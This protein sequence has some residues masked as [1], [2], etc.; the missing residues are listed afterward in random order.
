LQQKTGI[1]FFI[2]RT[3]ADKDI[4]IQISQILQAAGYKTLLQDEDFGHT[5]FMAMMEDGFLEVDKN[6]RL[7]ALLSKQYPQSAHCRAEYNYPLTHDP[8]NRDEKLIVLRIEECAPT[9][10]LKPLPYVDLVPTVHDIQRLQTAV[11]LAVGHLDAHIKTEP[12]W[13]A[14]LKRA[15]QQIRHS[16][17]RATPNFTGRQDE[18]SALHDAL[19]KTEDGIAA[20]TQPT[21]VHGLGGVGKSILAKEYAWQNKES[22]QGVWWLDA[23]EE[24]EIT[25]GLIELGAH[26]IPGLK[27]MTEK[28][29]AATATLDY[30]ATHFEGDKKPWL[31][32]YDNIE[33]EEIYR[34]HAPKGGAQVLLTSRQSHFTN[35]ITPIEINSWPLGD[36]I[37]YLRDESGRSFDEAQA[38]TLAET[39][40]CMPLALSHAAAF[41]RQNHAITV[42]TYLRNIETYLNK[43]PEKA[44]Y[45]DAVF[46]TY[47]TAIVGC[48]TRAPGAKAL[49]SLAAFMAPDNIPYEIYSQEAEDY[50]AA[51]QPLI[52]NE[53][54]FLDALG[55][56][57]RF[58]LISLEADNKTFSLHRLVQAAAKDSLNEE[59]ETWLAS[60]IN[61]LVEAYPG[62]DFNDWPAFERLLPHGQHIDASAPDDIEAPLGTLLNDIAVYLKDRADYQTAEP[63]FRRALESDEK[64]FGP[65]HPNVAI[66]LNNLALLLKDTNRPEEAE[67]L[68]R[69][70][71]ESHEKNFGPDHP[72]VA[73]HLNN[74][75]LLLK[76]TNRPEEAEPLYRRA[77]VSDE[78]NF[79]P[80]H[81][82]VAR[83]LN[84]LAG[85]LKDTNRPEEAEPLYRRALESDEKNFGPDHPNVAIDLNNL[86]ALLRTTNR[87]EEAE[88]LYRRALESDEKNFGPDHPNVAIRLNNLALLLKDTNRPKEAEPL[89][90][91]ALESNEKNF[92][93]DHPNVARDLNNLAGLLKGTNRPEEAEPLFH[94]SLAILEAS[95]PEGHPSIETVRQNLAILLQDLNEE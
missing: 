48:E 89:Y 47:Q 28:Q 42:E 52:E 2:S 35:Q 51:L 38:T 54:L 7:I 60:G 40:G 27:E 85:L 25:T 90:R 13:F 58:S 15:S 61:A 29:T 50:P 36:A 68:F 6:A 91:R 33:T 21:A 77:L 88:P 84:N 12:E 53:D 5:S 92:G 45:P 56:L 34:K 43:A 3:G 87:P 70:A 86:A 9:G 14:P 94:R 81:P 11:L 93:P 20:I 55:T 73:I 80:D 4:A 26:F 63:L 83:G 59:Q 18:L 66:H 62:Q 79:G 82:N 76:D 22:Y 75:A 46:A 10:F 41:L 37:S 17:I 57:D 1:D 8:E 30:L 64:N 31:L 65:D 23:E 24:S 49:L 71:L 67:P 69:R 16:E 32:I 72:N 78:K 44:D 19:T 74:L 95:L 39:L